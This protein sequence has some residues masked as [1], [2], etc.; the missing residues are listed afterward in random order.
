[1]FGTIRKHQT[2]LWAI[3]ITITVISF[4]IFFSPY[5]R[6][7]NAGRRGSANFGTI[8][9]RAI[10]EEEFSNAQREL[11]LWYFFQTG[12]K[13]LR[14]PE[15]KEAK[16][17]GF[18]QQ[19]RTYFRLLLAQKEEE[20]GIHVKDELVTQFAWIVIRP[21]ERMGVTSPKVFVEQVLKPQGFTADD[22]ERY[23]RH[24]LGFQE[25][26]ATFGMSGKLVT[27]D[28]AKGLYER[29]HQELATEAV[30]FDATN[31]LAGVTATNEAI[32]QFYSN[33]MEYYRIPDEIQVRYVKF[34]VTN[35]LA[36]AQEELKTNINE[37]IEANYQRLGTNF[38]PE[39]KTPEERKEKL[40]EALFRDKA[41]AYAVT[42]AGSFAKQLF[43][44]DPVRPENL[45]DLAKTNAI[46]VINGVTAQISEPFNREEAPKDMQVG[47]DFI[48]AAFALTPDEPFPSRPLA[49]R[50]GI[51]IIGF[52]KKIP[53]RIP[54]LDEIRDKVTEDYKYNEA[55]TMARLA[56]R[57]FYQTLTNGIAQGKTF[58]AVCEEAK[59]KL[60]EIPPFSISTRELP[61][62]EEHMS[63]NGVRGRGG[64]K[65]LAFSTPVG[66]VSPFYTTRE[67]GVI[68]NV[69]SKLPIDPAKEKA[70]LPDFIA[71]VRQSRQNEAFEM[72]FRNEIGRSLPWLLRQQQA[73]PGAA[74]KS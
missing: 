67:G 50:D 4:V 17:M 12:G 1:M 23:V 13:W 73:P 48:K 51:Y 22:F 68:L 62:V 53:T 10:G 34:N 66:K 47:S 61:M 70:D 28:E 2:W 58:A 65:E 21:L 19:Q 37:L 49:G 52:Y 7:S 29:E 54:P 3:I 35:Y 31:Y 24:E 64:L 45:D 44:M 30:F 39:A 32:S 14:W 25:L 56:G 5:Q 33:N 40:R 27:P 72:W 26:I 42:N 57:Q 46:A 38:S 16:E 20:L 9:G 59:I 15:D 74:A 71:A 8:N 41:M 18:G 36:Q 43:M 60:M 55:I 69:K 11:A 63:L 6:M